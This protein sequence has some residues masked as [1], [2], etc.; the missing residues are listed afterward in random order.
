M[1]KLLLV[2]LAVLTLGCVGDGPRSFDAERIAP[3][4][5]GTQIVE[6]PH[7]SCPQGSEP[8]GD[9]AAVAWVVGDESQAAVDIVVGNAEAAEYAEI[10]SASTGDY[11]GTRGEVCLSVSDSPR[12]DAQ[13]GEALVILGW[14]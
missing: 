4:L 1:S 5:E 9:C 6:P 8:I 14:C 2:A 13:D 3:L 11:R 7:E 12:V 10:S